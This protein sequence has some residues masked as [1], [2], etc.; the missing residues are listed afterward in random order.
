MS[1]TCRVAVASV[2][3]PSTHVLAAL[4]VARS[5]SYAS[6]SLF[7][8]SSFIFVEDDLYTLTRSL[9]AVSDSEYPENTYSNA[10]NTGSTITS[11]TSATTRSSGV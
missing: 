11:P 9:E 2:L 5:M 10:P 1:V 4:K 8:Y 3:P 6:P 7:V